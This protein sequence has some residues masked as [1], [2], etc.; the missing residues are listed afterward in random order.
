MLRVIF[1]WQTAFYETIA[2]AIDINI[3]KQSRRKRTGEVRNGTYLAK[4]ISELRQCLNLLLYVLIDIAR[5]GGRRT[6][7]I[8]KKQ[9]L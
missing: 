1:L 8:D 7:I 3:D 9:V 4:E 6:E 2:S 5:Q